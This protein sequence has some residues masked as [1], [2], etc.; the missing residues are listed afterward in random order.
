MNIICSQTRILF[1]FTAHKEHAIVTMTM[2]YMRYIEVNA[3]FM[4]YLCLLAY[5]GVKHI[6]CCVFVLVLPVSLDCPLLIAPSVLCL[7]REPYI[8]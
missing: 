2:F 6:L 3:V 7:F 5:S 1:Y 4:S 8:N